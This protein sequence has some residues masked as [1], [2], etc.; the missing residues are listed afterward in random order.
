MR[1][2]ENSRVGVVDVETTRI[3]PGR[4]PRTKFWGLAVEGE[5]YRRF[6]TSAD[7]VSFL[8]R[9]SDKLRLYNHHDFDPCQLIV[10]RIIPGNMRMRG[11]RIIRCEVAGHDWVNSFALFPSSLAKILEACGFKK[12]PLGCEAHEGGRDDC[13]ACQDALSI[14]NQSD[15]SDALASFLLLGE[16]YERECGID[17]IRGGFTTAAG[18]A[19]K[20]AEAHAGPFPL[21]LRYHDAVR[22]G[23]TEAFRVRD[24]GTATAYDVNSSYPFAYTDL[25]NADW[26]WRARVKVAK[27]DAPRPFFAAGPREEG[28]KFPAGR[29]ETW[30]LGST[31]ERYLAPWGGIEDV[32]MLEKIPVDLRWLK[33]VAPMIDRVYR[34]RLATVEEGGRPGM[35]FALKIFLNSLWGRM[36]MKPGGNLTRRTATAPASGTYYHLGPSDYLSFERVFRKPKANYPLAAAILCNGRGRLYDGMMRNGRAFYCDTDGIYVPEGSTPPGELNQM[37]L[38]AWKEEKTGRLIVRTVKDYEFAGEEKRKGGGKSSLWTVRLAAAHDPVR[39]VD[40]QRRTEYDKRRV[41]RDGTTAPL[42]Y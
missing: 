6:E 29:F 36:A 4:R 5:G 18:A 26:L 13:G 27:D 28:L 15:C 21:D 12:H 35:K 39:A 19:F 22:G 17:P 34:K 3:L 42:I 2:G 1:T 37:K 16:E 31:Y 25:P 33:K 24:C 11:A 23:R 30:F 20:A 10:D 9:R 41:R 40:R 38:G 7:L 8:A 14:R 32:T